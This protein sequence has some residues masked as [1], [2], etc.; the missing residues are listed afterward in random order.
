MNKDKS[1]R[2]ELPYFPMASHHPVVKNLPVRGIKVQTFG[3]RWKIVECP[4]VSNVF[5]LQTTS[6]LSSIDTV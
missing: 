3:T 5:F 2:L 4:P 6:N 1:S